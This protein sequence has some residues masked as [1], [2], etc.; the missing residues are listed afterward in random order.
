M[1][2]GRFQREPACVQHPFSSSSSLPA[3]SLRHFT[4]RTPARVP[5]RPSSSGREKAKQLEPYSPGSRSA[6]PR[7]R[8]AL[9]RRAVV[10]SAAR[11]LSP[12]RRHARGA[13]PHA[14]AGLPIL[15]LRRQPDRHLGGVDP[16]RV[17]SHRTARFPAAQDRP[18][19]G[20]PV[21]RGRRT[22]I[23]PRKTSTASACRPPRPDGPATC[24]TRAAS[25]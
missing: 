23:C 24:S 25:T 2:T 19:A 20:V 10:Q 4:L 5:A 9:S 18:R 22:I 7:H 17:G 15:E 16:A 21:G 8:G 12:R 3:L 6:P 14:R 11:P 13:G 1:Y